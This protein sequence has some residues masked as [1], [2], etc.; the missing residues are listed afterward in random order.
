M[1][2]GFGLVPWFWPDPLSRNI[3]MLQFVYIHFSL[4]MEAVRI[5][6]A[7]HSLDLFKDLKYSLVKK[8]GILFY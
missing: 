6:P 1:T 5:I 8:E 7:F 4:P 2:S 3:V